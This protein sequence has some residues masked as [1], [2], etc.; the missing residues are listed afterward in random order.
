[1]VHS[2]SIYDIGLDAEGDLEINQCSC[3]IHPTPVKREDLANAIRIYLAIAG[4]LYKVINENVLIDGSNPLVQNTLQRFVEHIK[5]SYNYNIPDYSNDAERLAEAR[6]DMQREED[7][8]PLARKG[9]EIAYLAFMK[10]LENG[11]T[12]T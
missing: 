10:K 7:Y 6:R 1:M 4:E 9:R 3:P 2:Q 5:A 12:E 8:S 11:R